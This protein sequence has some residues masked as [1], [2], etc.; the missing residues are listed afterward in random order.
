M[1]AKL[2]EEALHCDAEFQGLTE[3]LTWA[4]STIHVNFLHNHMIFIH[5]ELTIAKT[6]VNVFSPLKLNCKD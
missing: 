1:M 6:Q 3:E 4:P 5:L 2:E